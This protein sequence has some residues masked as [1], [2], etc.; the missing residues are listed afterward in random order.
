[1]AAI[2]AELEAA[3]ADVVCLQEVTS[4]AYALLAEWFS[5][6]GFS[7]CYAGGADDGPDVIHVATF[8]RSAKWRLLSGTAASPTGTPIGALLARGGGAAV[9]DSGLL[10]SDARG[11][12]RSAVEGCPEVASDSPPWGTPRGALVCLSHDWF[13]GRVMSK[14]TWCPSLL[15]VLQS[16]DHPGTAVPIINA[17]CGVGPSSS[18]GTDRAPSQRGPCTLRCS[19]RC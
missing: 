7:G 19:L 12:P 4:H 6:R 2:Q 10:L 18:S 1:M 9:L 11:G 8:Y 3:D 15:T 5:G 14:A 13:W 17:P 16:V